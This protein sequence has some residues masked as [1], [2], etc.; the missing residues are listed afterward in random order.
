MKKM[1]LLFLSVV[2]I[3]AENKEVKKTKPELVKIFGNRQVATYD[4]EKDEFN[5]V[6]G[7]SKDDLIKAVADAYKVLNQSYQQCQS[8]VQSLQALKKPEKKK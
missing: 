8:Q 2:A 4:P 1:L 6:E 7:A 5:L 3:G